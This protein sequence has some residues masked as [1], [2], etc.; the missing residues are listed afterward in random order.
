MDSP[1][2]RFLFDGRGFFGDFLHHV[3]LVVL[4]L[5]TTILPFA[6]VVQVW[7]VQSTMPEDS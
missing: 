5:E 2:R 6:M 4:R 3:V 1:A 7:C